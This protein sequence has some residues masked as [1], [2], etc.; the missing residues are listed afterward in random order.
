MWLRTLFY[1]VA[2]IFFVVV[3]VAAI[4]FIRKTMQTAKAIKQVLAGKELENLIVSIKNKIA[5]ML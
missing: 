5:P 3:I 2:I 4:V 1:I